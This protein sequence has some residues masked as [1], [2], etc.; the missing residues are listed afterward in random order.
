M[1]SRDPNTGRS[2]VRKDPIPDGGTPETATTPSTPPRQGVRLLRAYRKLHRKVGAALCA[3][4]FIISITGLL[5]GWKKHTGGIILPKTSKGVSAD[6]STWLPFDSLHQVAL[7]TL[8][9]S[10]SA[11]FSPELERIDARPQKG[12]VKFV[13]V[14]HYWEVQ[15]DGTTGQVLQI[16]RRTSDIIENIHDGSILD[17]W[18]DTDDEQFKLV[19]TSVMGLSLL[20]LSVTGFWL[21]YGPKRIRRKQRGAAA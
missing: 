1:S 9:D 11:E 20:G 8:R 21:W 5:L 6:L 17:F 2:H 16:S 12:S 7:R 19:Y 10:I 18:L 14:K 3:F 4:F 15:L 13:F